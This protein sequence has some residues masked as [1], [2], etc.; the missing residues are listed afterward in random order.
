[1]KY[2]SFDKP[3]FRP[4]DKTRDEREA[5]NRHKPFKGEGFFICLTIACVI[6]IVINLM[7]L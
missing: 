4:V 2:N 1:M 3:V 6:T 5:E 7:L